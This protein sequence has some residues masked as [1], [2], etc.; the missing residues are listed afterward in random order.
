MSNLNQPLLPEYTIDYINNVM[1]L[2]KPQF[3]SLR[4]LDDI[5]KENQLS[6]NI[7]TELYQRSINNL[8]RTFTAFERPFFNLAFELA[9]GVGKTK[10][11][12]AFMTYLYTN[13]GVKNFFVV[14]PSLTIY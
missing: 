6:K 5:L 7:E 1:A 8:Y 2:R 9:T 13:K 4:I 14:A 3:R 10:L 11:M 12:G